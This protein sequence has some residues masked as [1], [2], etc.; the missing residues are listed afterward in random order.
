MYDILEPHLHVH[1]F[2]YILLRHLMEKLQGRLSS[3]DCDK[4]PNVSFFLFVIA[5]ALLFPLF[6]S[7][8]RMKE[9]SQC[10]ISFIFS[11]P[12]D[13]HQPII[14]SSHSI[15]A[16]IPSY[17]PI[18]QNPPYSSTMRPGFTGRPRK[19][20]KRKWRETEPEWKDRLGEGWKSKKMLGRGSFGIVGLWSYE[21]NDK[22]QLVRDVAV[23]QA[24]EDRLT[25]EA[26]W[27]RTFTE[28]GTQHVPKMY[29]KLT[30]EYVFLLM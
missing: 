27:M 30:V 17:A 24:F 2:V 18:T 25:K 14:V 6:I 8:K 26:E 23:K 7:Q 11:R 12:R 15:P 22:N 28:R 13:K 16:S 29:G 21:G 4:E 20:N 9:Y 10:F 1:V 19:N 5:R 3:T